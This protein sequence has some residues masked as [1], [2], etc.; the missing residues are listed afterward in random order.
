MP[1]Y[2][3]PSTCD[4]C[5]ALD[6][7]VC[8]YVCP[9]DIMHLDESTGKAYNIEPDLCWECY[10]CVKACPRSAIGIRGY[11]DVVPMGASFTPRRGARS[12]EWS[13][14]YRDGR[15]KRF[16]F[17]IRTTPWGSIELY[18]GLPP[19]QLSDLKEPGLS[20]QARFLGVRSLPTVARRHVADEGA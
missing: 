20:G 19:P 11:A 14:Q 8:R 3:N 6:Q 9:S 5:R 12:I 15:T 4:G 13:G 7:P 10:A 18:E 1:T 17:V 2:V 16:E